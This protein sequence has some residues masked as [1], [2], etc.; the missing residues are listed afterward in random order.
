MKLSVAQIPLLGLS[1]LVGSVVVSSL[2]L[3]LAAPL[4]RGSRWVE[5]RQVN[6]EVT[7]NGRRVKVG[8]RL[9]VEGDR[10]STSSGSSAVLAADDGIGIINVAENTN[11]AVKSLKTL[12][13]GSKTTRF[14]LTRGQTRS[15]VR[16]FTNR[17]SSYEIETPGG[18]AGTRGTE[19]GVAVSPNGKTTLS[20]VQGTIAF[21]AQE[22]TVLVEPGYSALI[23]PG[24]PPTTP[25]FTTGDTQLKLQVLDAA[26][27]DQVRVTARV[28]PINL[29]LVNGTVVDTGG[30]GQLDT[31][32]PIPSDRK[33]ILIVRN[34]LGNQQVYELQVPDSTG[35][36]VNPPKGAQE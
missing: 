23:I 16:R 9:R 30:D 32:V 15:K 33:I 6:G 1:L 8:D 27:K 17:K 3:A 35:T 20:T 19:F 7:S 34:P 2:P 36:S 11:I 13:D 14:Y 4:P 25:R 26:N 12:P 29:V 5:V 18:V 31:V 21:S 22:K 28:D 24:Q 10:I